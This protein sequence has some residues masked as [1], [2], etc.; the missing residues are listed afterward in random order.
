M[1]ITAKSRELLGELRLCD[2]ADLWCVRKDIFIHLAAAL[3]STDSLVWIEKHLSK[4][5]ESGMTAN[6]VLAAVVP[7]RCALAAYREKVEP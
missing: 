6:E 5:T 2:S 1:T 7:V 4:H 3:D